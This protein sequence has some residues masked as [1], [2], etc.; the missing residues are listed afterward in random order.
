MFANFKVLYAIA[1]ALS[2]ATSNAAAVPGFQKR[3]NGAIKLDF[4]IER[5][6]K[7]I[8]NGN[9]T[10]RADDYNYALINEGSY[11]V[12]EI[13]VGS[14]QQAVKVDVDTGSSDLW[15]VDTSSGI[16]GTYGVY[17]HTTSSTFSRIASGFAVAYADQS[18]AEGDWV[19]DTIQ[20]GGTGG[21]SLKNQ[22]FGDATTS[23]INFGI[24]GIG[25]PINEATA[26]KYQNVPQSLVSQGYIH[27]NAYS[28]YLDS[29][30]AAQGS[31]LFGGIDHAK[32]SGSLVSNPVVSQN[33]LDLNVNSVTTNGQTIDIGSNYVLDSGTTINYL[34]PTVLANL[35]SALGAKYSSSG[36]YY[37]DSASDAKDI[38][39]NFDGVS[40]TIPASYTVG[41]FYD[42][43][44]NALTET[45]FLF[46]PQTNYHILGDVFLRNAYVVYD[47]DA[48][49]ISLAQAKFTSDENITVIS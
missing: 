47:L 4:N 15:V 24:L 46:L 28:L 39:V 33:D 25:F 26:D 32:Y 41:A 7:L 18:H 42:G 2:F 16:S 35:A 48:R 22:E 17:D 43:D 21:P 37:F 8:L 9:F 45:G 49:T 36:F 31:V 1:L 5:P 13:L 40:V 23:T 3:E 10:K 19:S 14:N 20:L 6:D 38:S 27:K 29:S 30:D 34:D 12:A 11:Y 44:G